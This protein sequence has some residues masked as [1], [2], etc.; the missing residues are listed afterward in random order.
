MLENGVPKL[1]DSEWEIMK[2]IW[3]NRVITANRIIEEL[4]GETDW[5]PKTIK[6]LINRLLKKKA[7]SFIQNKREYIYYPLVS[8]EDCIQEE[9]RS[10]LN[11]IYNGTLINMLISFIEES[12]LSNEELEELKG[13]IEEKKSKYI[14]E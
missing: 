9:N 6:A 14:L 10:F 3:N 12:E 1:A 2:I 11:K 8:E 7:I 13:I 4:E 5:K